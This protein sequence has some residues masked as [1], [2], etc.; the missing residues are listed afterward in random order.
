MGI[1]STRTAELTLKRRFVSLPFKFRDSHLL[2]CSLPSPVVSSSGSRVES[3]VDVEHRP[4]QPVFLNWPTFI[5]NAPSAQWGTASA[6]CMSL[7]AHACSNSLDSAT[8]RDTGL[9]AHGHGQKRPYL[10]LCGGMC[11]E[12]GSGE[13]AAQSQGL[14]LAAF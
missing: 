12:Q 8:L 7:Y 6:C 9:M 13:I 10:A 11:E 5:V 2:R 1:T 4:R 14:R 3:Q